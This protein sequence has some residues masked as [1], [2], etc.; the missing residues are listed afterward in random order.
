MSDFLT[1]DTKAIIL[2][3]GM[4]GGE[5]SVKPLTISKYNAIVRWLVSQNMRPADLLGYDNM[6]VAATAAGISS[7][8]LKALLGRGVELAFAVEQWQR[9]GIWIISRS[10][11]DYPVRYKK[12]LKN[13]AP[14]L[15]YGIGNRTLLQGGGVGIVGS[16]NVDADGSIF[17]KAAAIQCA[18]NSMTVVSGG[19]RGVDN[20]AMEAAFDAGG[21][22]IGV[23][24][25]EL[26][27][28]SLE[29][30]S[31]N[32]I[33]QGR[34]LLIS[35][36]H[37]TARFS[38]ATA[39]GRNKLIYAMADYSLV[40][41]AE[42][43]KGGTWAGAEEALNRVNALPVFVRTGNNTPSG[44]VKLLES[45]A[46]AWPQH[47]AQ[48]S[49]DQHLAELLAELSVT[50][51]QTQLKQESLDLGD[52]Q[53]QSPDIPTLENTNQITPADALY[54][55]VLPFII[56]QLTPQATIDELSKSLD[57]SQV[58]LHCWLSKAINEGQIQKTEDPVMF[59]KVFSQNAII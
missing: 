7:D 27:K 26:L 55:A 13:Q 33:A 14:P 32:A 31:R 18:T 46:I 53:H 39:M 9:S 43:K 2:L 25:E 20:I 44:N 34:L 23:L 24:A 41:S 11:Q 57:L 22:V 58:Q 15:L 3:C 51:Q 4:L 40:V 35:A 56:A 59:T 48:N 45:G 17:T 54:K 38:V 12:H 28:K 21:S 42:Y 16:R 52:M 50:K 6:D 10:D 37:P 30:Y 47:E 29:K 49:L 8:H 36:C 5:H 19:A 1:D